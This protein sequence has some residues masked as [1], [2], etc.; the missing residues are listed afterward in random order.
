MNYKILIG[1]NDSLVRYVEQ[2]SAFDNEY[3]GG[4]GA[5]HNLMAFI[6]MIIARKA[7]ENCKNN[8]AEANLYDS[9]YVRGLYELNELLRLCIKKAEVKKGVRNR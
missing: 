7:L 1:E 3:S 8:S 2:L 4:K 6:D 9:G 5:L